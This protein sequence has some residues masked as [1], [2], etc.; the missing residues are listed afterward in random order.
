MMKSSTRGAT[1]LILICIGL[2]MLVFQCDAQNSGH[3]SLA[4]IVSRFYTEGN[5]RK[6]IELA[7]KNDSTSFSSKLFYYYGMSYAALYNYPKAQEYFQKI[8]KQD[9][10]NV[11]YHFQFARLLLQSGFESDAIDEL[12][13]CIVLDSTYLPAFFQLGLIYN[14]QKKDPEKEIELFS[15]LNR[16]NPNDFL[17]LYYTGDA[18]K[19]LGLADSGIVFTQRSVNINPHY[20]PS[21][22]A[23]ANY[24]N[25]RKNYFAAME[26][27]QKALSIRPRDKD[28]V[29]QVGECYRKLGLL[30][31]ALVQF[32]AAIQLDTLEAIYHAQLGFAYFQLKQYDS[33]IAAYN[34]AVALDED[35]VQYYKNLAL[36]FQKIDS[37]QGVVQSY[38][39]GIKVLHPENISYVYNDLAAFYFKK[40]LWRDAAK[41]YQRVFDFDPDNDAALF[42]L[43][44]SFERIL[45]N[46]SAILA[47]QKYLQ[48]TE[49]DT[50]KFMQ[51]KAVEENIKSLKAKK[52]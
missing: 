29:F 15:Y 37:V 7:E 11:N 26:Y 42:W 25:S 39:R 17:S 36:A 2:V 18:L 31:E 46:D 41:T 51:R 10:T 48:K 47:F 12:K 3:D 8:V 30:E 40:N 34:K 49:G 9:S 38:Q 16:Q 4:Q 13:R 50:S 27:Y 23:V 19:R 5:Y 21:L 6:A 20:F 44:Y 35:N 24:M 14:F 28:I 43:G 1:Q 45:E 52:K 32:K 33:S 22:V